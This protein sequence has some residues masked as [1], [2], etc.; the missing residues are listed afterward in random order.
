[1]PE[2]DRARAADYARRGDQAFQRGDQRLG[3]ELATRALVVRLAACAYDCPD[4]A[5]SFVQLG[6]MRYERGELGHAAQSYRRAL[7]VL[8]PYA[9]S[10]PSW[11]RAT[12]AR[13]GTTCRAMSDPTPACAGTSGL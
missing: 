4:V 6:D 8:E 1:V 7:E 5:W 3:L 11:V 9:E 13:L 2:A 12:L 10:Q